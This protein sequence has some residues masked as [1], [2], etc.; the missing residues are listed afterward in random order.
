MRPLNS[1][2]SYLLVLAGGIAMIV[3]HNDGSLLRWLV[4]FLGVVF[5][6]PGLISLI[7]CLSR[8]SRDKGNTWMSIDV[9]AAVGSLVIGLIM[10]I[11]PGMV[12][13]IFV[14]VLAVLLLLVGIWQIVTL[15][16]NS[17]PGMGAPW[18]LYIL[19]VLALVGGVSMLFSP[20]KDTESAFTLI[21]GIALTCVGANGLF[22]SVAVWSEMRSLSAADRQSRRELAS[23]RSGD[24]VAK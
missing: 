1:F 22:M 15:S 20:L 19:P 10:L 5:A 17:W 14:Y 6:L 11:W 16:S 23:H 2:F 9:T 24:D 7:A 8:S 21:A 3:M 13:G 12:V 18:W 4:I